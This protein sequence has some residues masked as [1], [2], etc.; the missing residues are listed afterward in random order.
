MNEE[1]EVKMSELS[2][3]IE[4]DGEYIDVEIFEDGEGKWILEA[5]NSANDSLIWDQHFDTDVAALNELEKSVEL[6]GISKM[7]ADA[8]VAKIP[9][10]D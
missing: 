4:K 3:R 8:P 5:I 7:F 6:E 9:S 1:F 10:L 2:Q